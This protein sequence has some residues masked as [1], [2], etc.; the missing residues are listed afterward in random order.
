MI[1]KNVCYGILGRDGGFIETSTTERGA[2]N[3]ASRNGYSEVYAFHRV[4]WAVWKVS[5]K[6]TNRWQSV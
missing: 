5:T 2:K 3:H 6:T 1:M 4:S